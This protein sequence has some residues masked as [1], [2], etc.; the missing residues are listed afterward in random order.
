[1]IHNQNFFSKRLLVVIVAI[2]FVC[3]VACRP[4]GGTKDV[5]IT[6]KTTYSGSVNG[7]PVE[8]NVTANFN[9]GRGGSSTCKSTK[10]PSGFNL[11]FLGTHG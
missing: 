7:S 9:T 3:L 5:D 1:M 8:I 4:Q 6:S 10:L 11:A 2:L